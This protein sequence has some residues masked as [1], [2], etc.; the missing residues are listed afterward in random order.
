M[1]LSGTDLLLTGGAGFVGSALADRLVEANRV[2]VVDD[3]SNGHRSAVPD[4]ARFVEADLTDPDAVDRVVTGDLD[5]V[6]HL[7]AADK[8]VNSDAPREQFEANQAITHNLLERMDEVGVDNIAYTSSSTV[9]GEAPRPTPEDCPAEPISVYGAGKLAEEGLLSVYASTH[10]LTAWVF[11]FAN[12]VGPRD[13]EGVVPD[14][15]AKLR[16]DPSTLTILGDGRQE[17]SYLHVSDCVDA[18]C[19]V[20][21]TADADDP[22]HVYNLGTRTTTSVRRIADVVSEEMGVDPE[23]RFTGGDRGWPGDVPRMRLSIEKLAALGWEP[24]LS[25][26]AAIRRAVGELLAADGD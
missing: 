14:F 12:V 9:Y 13:R 10:D 7:A 15:V 23:Y 24:S 25:S 20:V 1:D 21:E 6:F 18:M 22:F 5:A 2:T 4:D 19:H 16:D 11:R 3:L 17:K 26:E 8:H